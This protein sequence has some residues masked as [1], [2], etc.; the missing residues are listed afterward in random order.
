MWSVEGK[1]N[2]AHPVKS[3]MTDG[4]NTQIVSGIAAGTEVIV[5]VK[6]S[7]PNA[8]QEANVGRGESSPFA[9]GPPGRNKKK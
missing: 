1:Q 5:G 7:D 3:G 4:T 8:D 6:V 9:P 2:K